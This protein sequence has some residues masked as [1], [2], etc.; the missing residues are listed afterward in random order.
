MQM[1]IIFLWSI[2]GFSFD[3]DY[4]SE[5]WGSCSVVCGFF[6]FGSK[7]SKAKQSTV[8]TVPASRSVHGGCGASGELAWPRKIEESEVRGGDF[9]LLE[10]VSFWATEGSASGILVTIRRWGP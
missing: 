9:A 8:W 2:L 1:Q 10:I 3:F 7:Q 5:F 4:L 6:L